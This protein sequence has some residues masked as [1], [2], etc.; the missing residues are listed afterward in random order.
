MKASLI[1]VA[2]ILLTQTVISETPLRALLYCYLPAVNTSDTTEEYS[3]L[4]D[5]INV[6]LR[7]H[8]INV[9]VEVCNDT[10]AAKLYDASEINS[11]FDDYD[12]VELDVSYLWAVTTGLLTFTSDEISYFHNIF[13]FEWAPLS[14][15]VNGVN[16]LIGSPGLLCSTFL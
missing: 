14:R 2:I 5:K 3:R 13:P 15:S 11:L 1:F 6:H 7:Q 10:T 8:N 4:A 9:V 16:S 12:I